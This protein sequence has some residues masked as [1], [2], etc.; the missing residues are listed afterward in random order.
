MFPLPSILYP[1]A[2]FETGA[3]SF[4]RC[5]IMFLSSWYVADFVLMVV[6][7]GVGVGGD[8][9]GQSREDAYLHRSDATLAMVGNRTL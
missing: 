3:A 6:V 4:Y 8:G 5:V 7:V 2:P 1:S 9:D